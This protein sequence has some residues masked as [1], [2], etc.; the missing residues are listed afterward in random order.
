MQN[1]ATR[2]GGRGSEI[3]AGQG[4]GGQDSGFRI[5]EK[6]CGQMICRYCKLK[7]ATKSVT[8]AEYQKLLE[9]TGNVHENKGCR[10]FR[11]QNSGKEASRVQVS[12]SN[13]NDGKRGA[14]TKSAATVAVSK[15]AGTNRECP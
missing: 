13:A 3:V 14:A 15:T 12:A 9:R 11:M 5:E 4:M 2:G 7:T 8:G 10:D 6:S 1:A